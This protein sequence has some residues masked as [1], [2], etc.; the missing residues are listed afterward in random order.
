MLGA[1]DRSVD[2]PGRE[3][4][5][6]GAGAG[7]QKGNRLYSCLQRAC[8]LLREPGLKYLKKEDGQEGREQVLDMR[9][10]EET[11]LWYQGAL[12]EEVTFQQI[13]PLKNE[14]ESD[15]QEGCRDQ[16]RL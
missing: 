2:A 5:G 12:L 1:E 11:F 9:L 16:A 10:A 15:L 13:E 8:S 4:K 7:R 3:K 6:V 14:K